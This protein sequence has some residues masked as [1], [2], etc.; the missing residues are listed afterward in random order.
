MLTLF[1]VGEGGEGRAESVRSLV[2]VVV[3]LE[4]PGILLWH[5]PVLKSPGKCRKRPMS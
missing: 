4:S 1:S 3:F 5:F 2:R